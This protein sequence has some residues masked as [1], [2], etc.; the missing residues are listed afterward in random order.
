VKAGW[1]CPGYGKS[2]KFVQ[3]NR[4]L[5]QFYRNK[6]YVFEDPDSDSVSSGTP[7]E[8]VGPGDLEIYPLYEVGNTAFYVGVLW[9]L[10]SDGERIGLLFSYV[11][12]S[13]KGAALYALQTLGSFVSYIP[14]RLGR[15]IALD[16]SIVCF[17]S[18]Y[19][20]LAAVA[21]RNNFSNVTIKRYAE[22]LYALQQCLNDNQTR[23]ESETVC[24]SIILQL[25]EVSTWCPQMMR[26]TS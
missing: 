4:Q 12:S 22:S 25:C 18:I 1:D 9:P 11:L 16:K 23:Y 26:P 6:N 24:A 17:C 10:Y 14:S 20:D 15:N 19:M 3:E 2:W 5:A 7:L 13:P 21:R 8:S